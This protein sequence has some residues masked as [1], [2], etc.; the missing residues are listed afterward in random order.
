MIDTNDCPICRTPLSLDSSL[1]GQTARCQRCGAE[2][3]LPRGLDD[4]PMTPPPPICPP[5]L[6]P[7]ICAAH[8]EADSGLPMNPSRPIAI[9]SAIIG[10]GVLAAALAVGLWR[11]LSRPEVVKLADG[12]HASQRDRRLGPAERATANVSTAGAPKASSVVQSPN[13]G[14]DRKR[15]GARAIWR[16][17]A[18]RIVPSNYGRNTVTGP[19]VVAFARMAA[20][21]FARRCS[22]RRLPP[23]I[24]S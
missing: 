15:A 18:S 23:L 13:D 24:R 7:P 5:P 3:P 6:P 10:L 20:F 21:A 2:T 19:I 11:T 1:P 17:P 16:S 22:H 9:Y 12:G 8:E 14:A 4:E